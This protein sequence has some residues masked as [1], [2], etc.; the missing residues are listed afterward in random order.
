MIEDLTAGGPAAKAGPG[1]GD[2]IFSLHGSAVRGPEELAR[3]VAAL[4]PDQAV[5][6]HYLRGGQ[7]HT[8]QVTLATRPS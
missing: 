7:Q 8:T 2:V 1:S 3:A 6:L 5:A 4:R